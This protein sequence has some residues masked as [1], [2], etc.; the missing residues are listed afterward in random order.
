MASF[1]VNPNDLT[2]GAEWCDKSEGDWTPIQKTLS[3]MP[4]VYG[5]F[6]V[7]LLVMQTYVDY[8]KTWNFY[9]TASLSAPTAIYNVAQNLRQGAANYQNADSQ[10]ADMIQNSYQHSQ[11]TAAVIQDVYQPSH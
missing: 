7:I 8:I 3:Q 11:A 9:H 6:N 5:N 4:T 10:G 1:Q 2:T